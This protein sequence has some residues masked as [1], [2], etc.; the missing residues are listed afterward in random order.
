MSLG[1]PVESAEIAQN[2]TLWILPGS[3]F[4]M[5]FE[6]LRRFLLVQEIFNPVLYVLISTLWMH[7]ILLYVLVIQFRLDINGIGI[8]TTWTFILNF[9]S[10]TLYVHFNKNLIPKESW[11]FI[12]KD[13]FSKL[14]EYLKYGVPAWLMLLLDW[15]AYELLNIIA[16][17]IGV[18]ELA[19]SVIIFNI[20]S[21]TFAKLNSSRV[22]ILNSSRSVIRNYKPYWK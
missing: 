5:Q 10:L 13:A 19:A 16:G 6:W 7:I 17:M 9:I 4:Q 3:F 1:L 15:W 22:D 21:N 8:A 2:Y 11:H 20:H 18:K 12:N 14:I